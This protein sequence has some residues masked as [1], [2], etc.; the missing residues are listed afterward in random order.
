MNEELARRDLLIG[1]VAALVLGADREGCAIHSLL[2]VLPECHRNLGA[3]ER[4]L[5]VDEALWTHVPANA[6]VVYDVV[7]SPA[8]QNPQCWY[9]CSTLGSMERHDA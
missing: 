7:F 6:S 1:A 5:A 4:L 8:V 3:S 9:K 2:V